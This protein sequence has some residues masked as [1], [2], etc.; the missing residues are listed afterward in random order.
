MTFDGRISD[1]MS[2]VAI[3]R[4]AL[5][6]ILAHGDHAVTE[7]HV[8]RVFLGPD[9]RGGNPLGVFL[10]GG[11][12]PRDRRLAVA[13]ELGFSETVFVDEVD[14][15]RARIAIYTPAMEMAFA[16][17][18]SVGT[19]WLLRH[20]RHRGRRARGPGRDHRHVGRSRRGTDVDPRPRRVGTRCRGPPVPRARRTSRP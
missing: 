14:G 9:G 11:V 16:G 4:V 5:A 17:H 8:L 19:S 18:P 13:H 7:L 2:V 15:D 6:R 10:D 12:F 20:E 1:A 3:Q